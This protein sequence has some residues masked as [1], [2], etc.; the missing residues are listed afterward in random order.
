MESLLQNEEEKKYELSQISIN[1]LLETAKWAKFI[2]IV[3]FVVV[4]LLLVV[5]FFMGFFLPS[6]NGPEI[7][8]INVT[9]MDGLMNMMG[10]MISVIYIIIAI[11]YFFP[12]L[13]LFNFSNMAIKAIKQDDNHLLNQS[14]IQIRKHFKFIGILTLIVVLIYVIMFIGSFLGSF[15][16][17]MF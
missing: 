1:N 10:P 16:G 14:F 7:G 12:V 4:A 13:F 2:A 5:A 6:I 15:L 9:E 3:G 17:S 8:D 11:I